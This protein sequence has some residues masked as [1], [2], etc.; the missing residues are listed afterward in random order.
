MKNIKDEIDYLMLFSGMHE[1]FLIDKIRIKPQLKEYYVDYEIWK[2][3]PDGTGSANIWIEPKKN[4][5]YKPEFKSPFPE[6]DIT[7]LLITIKT[8]MVV[9]SKNNKTVS[10][11]IA[12]TFNP[13][14]W[15]GRN[16]LKLRSIGETVVTGHNRVILE[17]DQIF[18]TY[19][20]KYI[21]Q[22]YADFVV[23]SVQFFG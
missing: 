4:L 10:F 2:T 7:G 20:L 15:R 8:K 14:I 21:S 13:R 17:Q 23:K 5:I 18:S 6:I 11:E 16:V 9:E 22:N 12:G 19:F 3:N 1:E